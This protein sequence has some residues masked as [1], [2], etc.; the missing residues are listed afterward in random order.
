M[1]T[2]L[3]AGE[4]VVAIARFAGDGCAIG[5]GIVKKLAF[6]PH[7]ANDSDYVRI[8][9]HHFIHYSNASYLAQVAFPINLSC[10]NDE[11][12]ECRNNCDDCRYRFLC[13]T[14]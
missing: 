6:A 3:Y 10:K 9:F 2:N 8:E 4:K 1:R 12:F 14:N 11:V 7:G 13:F 5:K